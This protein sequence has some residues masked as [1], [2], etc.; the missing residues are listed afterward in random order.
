[1]STFSNHH[2]DQAVDHYAFL[3]DPTAKEYEAYL[4]GE[5]K[6]NMKERWASWKDHYLRMR[7]AFRD[8]LMTVIEERNLYRRDMNVAIIGPGFSPIGHDFGED[9]VGPILRRLNSI[10]LCDISQ[11]VCTSARDEF[12]AAAVPPPMIHAMQYDI[13]NGLSTV[14]KQVIG[15]KLA[16]IGT[17]EKLSA[18]TDH[19]EGL[20]VGELENQILDET[21]K[22][23]HIRRPSLLEGGENVERTWKLTVEGKP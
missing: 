5:Y 22:I 12:I 16:G 9:D 20:E 19:L 21:A 14:C 23:P 10:V 6:H 13:T 15:A 7:E 4:E 17:E 1:M 8:C 18:F 11:R 3:I 2:L